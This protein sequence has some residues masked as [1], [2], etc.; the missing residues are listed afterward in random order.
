LATSRLGIRASEDLGK[1]LRADIWLEGQINPAAG[2][3][4]STNVVANQLFNREANIGLTGTFGSV[5]IGRQDVSLA[6]DIDTMTSQFNNFGFR[7][8]NGTSVELGVDQSNVIKY[9]SPR[10]A[11]FTVQAGRATNAVGATT[12]AGTDQTSA[13]VRFNQ[14]KLAVHAGYQKND[15]ASKNAERT[16]T[17]YGA[18][19]D[20]GVASVGYSYG[21]G[22][23][24]TTGTVKSTT[25]VAS[26]RVP[27]GAGLNAHAVYAMAKNGA[28]ATENQGQAYT[29]GVSKDMSKRTRLYAAYTA[30]ENQANSSM[31]MQGQVA[32]PAAA[33]LD[34]KTVAVGISHT[35]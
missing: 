26:V 23:V 21:E 6:Q 9:T 20:F 35:F 31:V 15:G 12:D 25:H 32:A 14:G 24:S 27:L 2:T 16:F 5:R 10:V 8:V 29:V 28:Q 34:P 33:G 3:Q 13:H 4:G 17:A 1:G 19:Y 7:P 22:D 11:G 30:V 18:A